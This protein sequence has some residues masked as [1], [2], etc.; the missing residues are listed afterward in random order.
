MKILAIGISH[1]QNYT[2]Q[3]FVCSNMGNNYGIVTDH[4]P[5]VCN[6]ENLRLHTTTGGHGGL[7]HGTRYCIEHVS[8][9]AHPP[10]SISHDGLQYGRPVG[11]YTLH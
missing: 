10:L 3:K 4:Y 9:S 8:L 6:H 7:L 11:L 2:P 5:I 1:I